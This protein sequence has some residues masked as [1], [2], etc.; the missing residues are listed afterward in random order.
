MKQNRI[1]IL[2]LLV[3]FLL[4]GCAQTEYTVSVN[5]N[6][7]DME[8]T[9]NRESSTI[10]DGKHTYSYAVSGNSTTITYPNGGTYH[11]TKRDNGTSNIGWSEKYDPKA[12]VEGDT[13]VDV[14]EDATGKGGGNP[15]AGL[16]LMALGAF[17]TFK[18]EW[19]WYL[20]HGWHYKNAELSEISLVVARISGAAVIVIGL[21]CLF[22]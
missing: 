16:L 8:F 3:V 2:L 15:F 9:V 7:K 17:F 19:A 21:F 10:S 20:S 14:V 13:L 5:Y 4:V 12:Y 18:P 11:E 6:G 22:V 1:V